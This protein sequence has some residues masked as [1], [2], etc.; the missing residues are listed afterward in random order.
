[1]KIIILI[2]SLILIACSSTVVLMGIMKNVYMKMTSLL[3][4]VI[5]NLSSD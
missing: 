4:H 1:M 3:V 5:T 2:I